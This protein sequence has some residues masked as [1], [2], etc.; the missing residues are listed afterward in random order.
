MNIRDEIAELGREQD[1]LLFEHEQWMARREAVSTSPVRK[2]H[3]EGVL[4]HGTQENAQA[5][6]TGMDAE[7]SDGEPSIAFFGDERDDLLARAVGYAL[8]EVRHQLRR[9]FRNQIIKLKRELV[10]D[11]R[12]AR[13]ERALLYEE[14]KVLRKRLD[15]DEHG[16]VDELPR[17]A[18]DHDRVVEL[19]DWRKRHA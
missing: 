10:G 3:V 15:L 9:E 16:R 1:R 2:S 7:P 8:S 19:P 18:R 11:R 6:A 12:E 14:I 17:K 4:V 13:R 5:S